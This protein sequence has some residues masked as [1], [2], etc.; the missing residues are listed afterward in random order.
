MHFFVD[1]NSVSE[2]RH[3]ISCLN[4]IDILQELKYQNICGP[5]AG[6]SSG[7]GQG[8]GGSSQK[9]D[10][11]GSDRASLST[12]DFQRG[13]RAVAAGT[14]ACLAGTKGVATVQLT[15]APSG[16]VLKVTVSGLLAGTPAGSC[17]ERVVKTATFPA[18]NGA[19]QSFGYEYAVAE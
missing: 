18:W 6:G 5:G 12:D 1:R 9:V 2:W 17:V 19:S 15:V 4:Q 8:T 10:K 7:R 11:R 13:M 3:A 16:R 14:Q